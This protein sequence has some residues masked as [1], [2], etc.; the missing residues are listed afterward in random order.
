[1]NLQGKLA[2]SPVTG[3]SIF[4]ESPAGQFTRTG[5]PFEAALRLALL[6]LSARRL[7][8]LSR[9]RL[10]VPSRLSALALRPLG[11]SSLLSRLRGLAGSPLHRLATWSPFRW[12]LVRQPFRAEPPLRLAA[13]PTWRLSVSPSAA[14]AAWRARRFTVPPPGA[15]FR[16]AGFSACGVSQPGCRV[17]AS[18]RLAACAFAAWRARRFAVSPPGRL[19]AWPASPPASRHSPLP[20]ASLRLANR[21]FR[22]LRELDTRCGLPACSTQDRRA[23]N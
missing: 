10:S 13:S 14:F 1:M 17:S 2:S 3:I 7:V 8:R 11:G 9:G 20:G 6:Y 18:L 16:V 5:E 23:T 4:Q 12:P 15:P 21:R 19:S 22:G